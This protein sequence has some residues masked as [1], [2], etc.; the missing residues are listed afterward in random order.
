ML[1]GEHACLA[2]HA[3]MSN[4]RPNVVRRQHPI[5]MTAAAVD[6]DVAAVQHQ[7][8]VAGYMLLGIGDKGLQ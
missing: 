7:P 2:E 6:G 4:R 5:E 1:I 8:D 3:G